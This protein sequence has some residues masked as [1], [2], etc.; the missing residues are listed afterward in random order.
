MKREIRSDLESSREGHSD[1]ED[2]DAFIV[3]V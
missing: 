2:Q 1:R 3:R